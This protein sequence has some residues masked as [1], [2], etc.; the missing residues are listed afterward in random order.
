MGATTPFCVFEFLQ[1]GY[2]F[3]RPLGMLIYWMRMSQDALVRFVILK[4]TPGRLRAPYRTMRLI[5][6][7]R[8]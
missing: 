6:S 2:S 5:V 3:F 1:T 4:Y 7:I 8:V